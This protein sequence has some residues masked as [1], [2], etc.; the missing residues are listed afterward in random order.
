MYDAY[1]EDWIAPRTPGSLMNLHSDVVVRKL[2]P[3]NPMF[4]PA[5]ISGNFAL[6]P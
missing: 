2:P 4:R 5:W 3:T 1:G 6:L